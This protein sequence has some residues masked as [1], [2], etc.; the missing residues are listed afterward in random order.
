MT[1]LLLSIKLEAE[2]IV[3]LST[4][5]LYMSSYVAVIKRSLNYKKNYYKLLSGHL[6]DFWSP[7]SWSQDGCLSSLYNISHQHSKPKGSGWV[8]LLHYKQTNKKPVM[9]WIV[10]LPKKKVGLLTS[11]NSDCDLTWRQG[12]YG[13]NHIKVR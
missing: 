4:S 9:G 2:L 3:C 8:M 11:S 12:H 10:S 1:Y 13:G 5:G 7:P 6:C